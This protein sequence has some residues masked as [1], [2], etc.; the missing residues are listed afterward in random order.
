MCQVV[1]IAKMGAGNVLKQ[2]GIFSGEG[3]GFEI[4]ETIKMQH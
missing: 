1:R 4:K 2:G 3:E